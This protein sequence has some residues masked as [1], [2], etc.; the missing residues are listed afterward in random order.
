[1]CCIALQSSVHTV[2]LVNKVLPLLVTLRYT[3][4]SRHLLWPAQ[5]PTCQ[6]TRAAANWHAAIFLH[7]LMSTE[8]AGDRTCIAIGSGKK[9]SLRGRLPKVAKFVCNVQLS[10]LKVVSA[11][12]SAL[13]F[14]LVITACSRTDDCCLQQASATE[15]TPLVRID[16]SMYSFATIAKRKHS[17][18]IMATAAIAGHTLD[19][20]HIPH[21]YTLASHSEPPRVCSP[22]CST[23]LTIAAA[24]TC[25]LYIA[26]IR[27]CAIS[28]RALVA[29]IARQRR[30]VLLIVL[31]R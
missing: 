1:M 23:A 3:T 11:A 17:T 8:T 21:S 25:I 20:S 26:G 4:P 31:V 22:A 18:H 19:C 10:M 14:M 12:H 28:L 29:T 24:A 9:V 5:N 13:V 2:Q 7:A 16:S 15:W 6:A 30:L 27:A